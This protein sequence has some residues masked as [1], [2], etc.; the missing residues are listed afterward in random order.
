MGKEVRRLGMK[1]LITCIVLLILVIAGVVY[2]GLAS[3][4]GGDIRAY[5]TDNTNYVGFKAPTLSANQIWT[6]PTID[7]SDDGMHFTTD[8][9]GVTSWAHPIIRALVHGT[10]KETMDALVTSD[11]ATVTM[12][13]TNA[14]GGDL[15]LQ[16]SD[17]DT[18]FS[19]SSG[20]TI[21]L[22]AGSDSSP[23]TN[24]IYILQS[25]KILTK[26]T[27]S[28]PAAEHI[29]VGF[30][31]VQS[32]SGVQTAGGS[33]INQNWNDHLQGTDSQ[34]H[35]AHI[36]EK[37][38]LQFATYFDGIDANG[39]S[40]TSY[41][42]VTAGD[43]RFKST[44]G[45][46]YQ[47]HKQT[48]PAFDTTGGADTMH[49]KN[50]SGDAFH[51]L[52]NLFDITAD[53]TGTTIANNKYF[54]LVIWGV[55]N[56]M[57]EHQTMMI[58]LPA[59][60]YNTQAS[61]ENDVSGFDDF[62][63]PRE[64]SIDSS[65]G[66]LV[67][68]IT[69]Q[70]GGTWSEV[71]SVD[72]RG[73]N[74]QTA[75]GGASGVATVFNDNAFRVVAVGDNTEILAFDVGTNVGTGTTVTLQVPS[76]S[77]D[78]AL[79]SQTDGTI[80]HGAD[81]AGLTDDDH[82]AYMLDAGT[83]TDNTLIRADGTDGRIMQTSGVVV[84]DSDN[85]TAIGNIELSGTVATTGSTTT[86]I[87]FQSTILDFNVAGVEFMTF[88]S[89]TTPD[90]AS[91]NDGDASMDFIVNTSIGPI[92][93]VDDSFGMVGIGGI[94]EPAFALDVLGEIQLGDTVSGTASIHFDTTGTD[95]EF[96]WVAGTALFDLVGSGLLTSGTVQGGTL[97]D[98]TATITGGNFTGMGNITGSDTDI[99][100][101]TGD[102]TSTGDVDTGNIVTDVWKSAD[103]TMQANWS[104]SGTGSLVLDGDGDYVD[105]DGVESII[106]PTT[107]GISMWAK[108]STGKQGDSTTYMAITFED[109]DLGDD[110][111]LLFRD[112]SNNIVARYREAATNR[113]AST[114]DTNME[115]FQFI[116]MTWN[117]GGDVNLYI[118][119]PCAGAD[120]TTAMTPLNDFDITNADVSAI[121]ARATNKTLQHWPGEMSDVV[122]WDEE[123]SQAELQTVFDFGRN[124][125]ATQMT[126]L[127]NYAEVTNWWPFTS[128]AEDFEA[129]V[130]GAF[131][132][133]AFVNST[134]VSGI[135]TAEPLL[136]TD[137]LTVVGPTNLAGDVNITGGN[138]LGLFG[139]LRLNS[140]TG[141]TINSTAEDQ[142]VT[143]RV[144]DGGTT[145]TVMT[146]DGSL[147]QVVFESTATTDP[148]F[149]EGYFIGSATSSRFFSDGLT[150]STTT[151]MWIGDESINTT[152]SG[153]A[154][155]ENF[156]DST[157]DVWIGF[158]QLKFK[159]FD[160]KSPLKPYRAT[161]V[162]A[163]DVYGIS[164]L[165][166]YVVVPEITDPNLPLEEQKGWSMK[167]HMMV[168]EV[169]KGMLE[170]K[171]EIDELK[172]RDEAKDI[173]MADL[174]RRI[175]ILE[176]SHTN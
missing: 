28:W 172:A 35:I 97:T 102:Y 92:L 117:T 80:D 13:L 25:D 107:G 119:D 152:A 3:Y 90:S 21:V 61:A 60:F 143:V 59:G 139:S 27:S 1:R 58:N 82:P 29:R 122:I 133:N 109:D 7:G 17:G 42:V 106:N 163:Q 171:A 115:T 147:A 134:S 118:G 38:R 48:F 146:L 68:R 140:S 16:L 4:G 103:E 18:T 36:A 158:K 127:A 11:G 124:P 66:F 34:G 31:F 45:R 155:K 63:I 145:T 173:I 22:T 135:N 95:G 164:E 88:D 169:I 157:K 15:T 78:I 150:G 168:P 73:S 125:T 160:W 2:A 54:N 64:F 149:D 65:V 86:N 175:E 105:I 69:I 79:T 84:D 56:K 129:V 132:G 19:T 47:L 151:V 57:N 93:V 130:D 40:G 76:A 142:D 114:A 91:I 52:S 144:N 6:L 83:P 81:V 8:A 74:P 89:T 67:C 174:V 138:P 131:A 55:Q 166:Q 62:T 41:L 12:T 14:A 75:S 110:Q 137:S 51:A 94:T 30:F 37:L 33:L 159:D 101:G 71:S 120:D 111:I 49:V 176:I 96:K 113:D 153:F 148:L 170:L 20:N 77:G 100:A 44:S 85:V 104:D 53:S 43:T 161:G 5:E 9:A 39:D 26:S 121:A 112:N 108:L 99:S 70:M 10:F 162:I 156:T 123:L 154:S 46:V 128:N 32:A 116:A 23:T 126:G 50:W 136:T 24:Y 87:D 72:L 98:G 141:T 167:F 165:R